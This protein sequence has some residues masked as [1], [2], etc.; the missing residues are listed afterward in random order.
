MGIIILICLVILT[1]YLNNK[2]GCGCNC[3]GSCKG[4]KR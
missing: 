4:C 3:D 2:N 1:F